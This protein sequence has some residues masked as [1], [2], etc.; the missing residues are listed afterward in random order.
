MG[1]TRAR[2]KALLGP[3]ASRALHSPIAEQQR[4]ASLVI[5]REVW[6]YAGAAQAEG[7]QGDRQPGDI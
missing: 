3:P 1:D 2:P 7:R 4:Q 6:L 5:R